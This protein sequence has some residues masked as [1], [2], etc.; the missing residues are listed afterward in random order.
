MANGVITSDTVTRKT[1]SE[2]VVFNQVVS[3]EFGGIFTKFVNKDITSDAALYGK[4]IAIDAWGHG[5]IPMP[6]MLRFRNNAWSFT[7]VT[8][9][10][11]TTATVNVTFKK[12]AYEV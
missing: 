8:S 12:N 2:T 10:N 1:Y 3:D 6:A 11:T 7:V 5:A 9:N 4:P